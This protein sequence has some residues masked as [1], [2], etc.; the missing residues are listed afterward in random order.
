MQAGWGWRRLASLIAAA[1]LA[2]SASGAAALAAADLKSALDKL[3]A[4]ECKDSAFTC[5]DL[6]VP[7]DRAQPGSNATITVRFAVSLASE[8]SKGILFYA[9][10][11]PGGSGLQAI[12]SYLGSFD[13]RLTKEMDIVFFDQRGVGPLNGIRCP[14]AGLAFD[15]TSLSLNQPEQA[16]AA[17][18]SFVKACGLETPHADLLPYLATTDAIQDLEDFRRAIGSPKVWLYGESY[19]TQFAQ[20][21]A[22]RYPEALNGLILDGVVDLTLDAAKY[23]GEDVR[24]VEKLLAKTLAGCDAIGPCRADMGA[25]A[26]EVYDRL[27]ARLNAAPIPVDYPLA[28]GGFAKRALSAAILETNAFYALYGP[29][30]RV[31][32]LRA[33]AAA[34]RNNLVPMLRLGYSN[35]GADP[36]TLEPADDPSWYGG[37]YYGITCPDYDDAGRDPEARVKEILAEARDLAPHAPRLIRDFYAERLVCAFWPAKGRAERP[38]PFAG[39]DYPTLVLNSDSDPATPV[40]NGY[41][42]FAQAKNASMLTMQGGPHVIWGRGLGCPDQIVFGLMLDGRRPER[43]EQVCKQDFL[44][45][46]VPLTAPGDAFALARGVETEL[47]QLPELA[48]WDT[49]DPITVGCD[50]GGSVTATAGEAGTDYAFK[51]CAFWPNLP[52]TG[53]GVEIDA[54]DGTQPDGLTLKLAIAGAHAGNLTYRH[55]STAEA[56]SLSG[57]Y[58]GKDVSTPRPLP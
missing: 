24:T 19:G 5:V 16:I 58:D 55:D 46:Y 57:S 49:I 53:D 42:V 51:D 11:G 32:F 28:E 3:G 31:A 34:G 52:A 54:G 2:I 48:D 43:P 22:T 18:R 38:A 39:G 12:E 56:M 37:A 25:P 6:A 4:Q 36:Q 50:F 47:A 33:L 17:A 10:G 40:S 7:V 29:D 41:A 45:A 21:Y 15:T 8:D 14:K 1:F 35:I 23:Y 30:S 13:A 27:A 26:A 20:T 9:V 44:D